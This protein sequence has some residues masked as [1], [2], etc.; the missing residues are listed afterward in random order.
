M[1][2][3]LQ[4][5]ENFPTP[6]VLFAGRVN[7]H[8]SNRINSRCLASGILSYR[9][10]TEFSDRLE[11]ATVRLMQSPKDVKSD[12]THRILISTS[13]WCSARPA[14]NLSCIS[15]SCCSDLRSGRLVVEELSL[16]SSKSCWY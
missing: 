7:Y 12:D 8:S 13:L 2:R 5:G 6:R 1:R 14:P 10:L 3:G 16:V 11:L 9:Y 15:F 4:D